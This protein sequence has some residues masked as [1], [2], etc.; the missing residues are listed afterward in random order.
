MSTPLKPEE[1]GAKE[2]T[3]LIVIILR[4]AAFTLWVA[5]TL[6]FVFGSESGITRAIGALC[7]VM[8]LLSLIHSFL[9]TPLPFEPE[10]IDTKDLA[11]EGS[12]YPSRRHG[13]YGGDYGH[14]SVSEVGHHHR[15]H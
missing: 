4:I 6:L 10:K 8:G 12:D 5:A 3:P 11:Y 14:S 1:V 2:R 9:F 15:F 13:G 7:T